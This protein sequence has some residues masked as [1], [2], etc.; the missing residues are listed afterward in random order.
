MNQ[1]RLYKVILAPHVSEKATN[2]ISKNN[3]YVFEVS[4]DSSKNEIKEAIETLFN[5]K[6]KKV[7]TLKVPAKKRTFRNIEGEKQGWKKAYVT[8][9]P[10]QKLEILGA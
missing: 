2:A 5:T 6:V 3:E 4:T 10:D 7:R 9:M 8:L 1:E